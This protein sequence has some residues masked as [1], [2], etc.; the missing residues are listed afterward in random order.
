MSDNT[1]LDVRAQQD[2]QVI[3]PLARQERSML[4]NTVYNKTGIVGKSFFQDQIGSWSMTEKTTPNGATPQNDPNLSRTRID[5]KTYQDARIF[6][7]SLM[8]QELADPMSAASYGIQSSVGVKIDE[9]IYA[10]LGGTANRGETGATAV[11]FPTA[12]TIAADYDGATTTTESGS[13]KSKTGLTVAKIRHA[14]K[15]LDASGVPLS[16]RWFVASATAK[17]QLLGNT[18]VT[19]SDY[20]NVKALV[21]GDLGSF[22]GFKF[23]FL[24]D[25]IVTKTENIASYYAYHKTGVCFGMLEELFVRMEERADKSYSKQIYYEI[26]GGAGRLEEKKVVKVLGDETVVV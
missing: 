4:Y 18:Q 3:L 12:Q 26:S 1:Q 5:M 13:T 11:T 2:S 7:R 24:P 21:S 25:G 9:I 16:E 19:S 15:I 17:E 14:G 20:N 8:L 22:Y 10:A 6:D 23:V